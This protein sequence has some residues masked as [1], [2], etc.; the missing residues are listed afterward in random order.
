MKVLPPLILTLLLAA[1]TNAAD[2]FGKMKGGGGKMMDGSNMTDAGKKMG[3]MESSKSKADKS[4]MEGKTTGKSSNGRKPCK[5]I[6]APSGKSKSSKGGKSMMR[7]KSG[8]KGMM[9]RMS[10]SKGMMAMM[11]GSKGM[12]GIERRELR[13]LL[14]G[15]EGRKLADR[16][17]KSSTTKGTGKSTKGNG[18]GKSSNGG[19]SSEV[20]T[21]PVNKCSEISPCDGGYGATMCL[22]VG[23]LDPSFPDELLEFCVPS[24]FVDFILDYGFGAFCGPCPGECLNFMG[25]SF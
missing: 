9:R 11:G 12:M 19:K 23:N 2:V 1:A 20:D 21:C 25:V 7:L 16:K 22:P 15:G 17:G 13:E 5:P 10:G 18:L 6:D 24:E 4:T 14:R 8:S 3:K